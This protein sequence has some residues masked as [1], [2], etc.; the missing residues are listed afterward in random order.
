MHTQNIHSGAFTPLWWQITH[1]KGNVST[2]HTVPSPLGIYGVPNNLR[3]PYLFDERR[4]ASI[5]CSWGRHLSSALQSDHPLKTNVW[6]S[7]PLLI[8]RHRRSTPGT[9][10]KEKWTERPVAHQHLY[11]SLIKRG[12]RTDKQDGKGWKADTC[13]RERSTGEL[14]WQ[15]SEMGEGSQGWSQW[16]YQ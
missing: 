9:E 13:T 3:A 14:H 11:V 2:Y 15:K 6:K 10:T 12:Y 8:R 4:F 5:R 7:H 1:R 16:V